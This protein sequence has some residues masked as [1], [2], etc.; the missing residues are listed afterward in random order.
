VVY[1]SVSARP[2]TSTRDEFNALPPGCEIEDWSG[3][4][5]SAASPVAYGIVTWCWHLVSLLELH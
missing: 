3:C 1:S 2:S 4:T 5:G